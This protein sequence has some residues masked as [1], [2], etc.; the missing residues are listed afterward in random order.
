MTTTENSERPIPSGELVGP[1]EPHEILVIH[2]VKSVIW[3]RRGDQ[4]Q[5]KQIS[6]PELRDLLA[7]WLT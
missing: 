1:F 2:V 3:A 5:M 4:Q 6:W 7:R